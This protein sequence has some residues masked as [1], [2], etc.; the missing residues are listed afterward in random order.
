MKSK[1]TSKKYIGTKGKSHLGYMSKGERKIQQTL[2]KME[3]RYFR[4]S[5]FK[6]CVGGKLPNTVL[7]PFDFSIYVGDEL[8][9]LVEY[10]GIQH[11]IPTFTMEDWI[12]T[13]ENDAIKRKY[14]KDNNIPLLEIDF[15]DYDNIK[16]VLTYF[17]QHNGILNKNKKYIELH[18]DCKTDKERESL[19]VRLVL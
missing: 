16:K 2:I 11:S 1:G 7:L 6:G 10:Q 3:I 12:K 18:G 19:K 4:E 17:L 15:S 5:V 8:Q 13:K 9:A 14:C